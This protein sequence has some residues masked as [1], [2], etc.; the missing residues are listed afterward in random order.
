MNSLSWPDN[1]GQLATFLSSDTQLQDV[2]LVCDDGQRGAHRAV[3]AAGSQ[4][5]RDVFSNSPRGQQHVWIYLR[6]ISLPQLNSLL[7]LLYFG[8]LQISDKE[9]GKFL[10]ISKDL[11]IVDIENYCF[12][13]QKDTSK[14]SEK[15]IYTETDFQN[16]NNFQKAEMDLLHEPEELNQSFEAGEDNLTGKNIYQPMELKMENSNKSKLSEKNIDMKTDFQ[17]SYS[18]FHELDI[19][20][21]NKSEEL[22]QSFG[23]GE[24]ITEKKLFQSMEKNNG[25]A[26]ISVEKAAKNLNENGKILTTS[27]KDAK[28]LYE[29]RE[30]KK[31]NQGESDKKSNLSDIILTRARS[32][33]TKVDG[34]WECK[35]CSKNFVRRRVSVIHAHTHMEDIRYECN[36]CKAT[37][38]TKHQLWKHNHVKHKFS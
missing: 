24:K 11:K 36:I 6:G 22:Y 28:N 17:N 37:L 29:F 1:S 23:L 34:L 7:Q 35:I 10:E 33:L 31:L 13:S 15:K 3:L 26:L 20:L 21:P 38:K 14:S 27:E 19:C 5:F 8:H 25:K 2:T 16:L 32:M 12:E 30:D 18:N 4:F 9:F